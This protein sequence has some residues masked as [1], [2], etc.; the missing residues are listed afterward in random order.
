MRQLKDDSCYP[1]GMHGRYAW[2]LFPVLVINSFTCETDEIDICAFPYYK[3]S[4]AFARLE[5]M[6]S[7][8]KSFVRSIPGKTINPFLENYKISKRCVTDELSINISP[9]TLFSLV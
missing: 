8:S 5:N 4:S 6:D 3:Y 1:V 9:D 2:S 7:S